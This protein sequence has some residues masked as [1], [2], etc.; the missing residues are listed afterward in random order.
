MVRTTI[1]LPD[2][3][4]RELKELAAAQDRSISWLLREAFRLSRGRLRQAE[5]FAASFDRV[6]REVGLSLR[7]RGIKPADIPRV[8]REVRRTRSPVTPKGKARQ[9]VPRMRHGGTGGFHHL[10]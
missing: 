6:W 10:G 9:H 3:E 5:P 8:I 1:V 4:F 2:E 7:Q